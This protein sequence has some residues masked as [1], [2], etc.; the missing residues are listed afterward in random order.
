MLFGK[1][2]KNNALYDLINDNNVKLLG[3]HWEFQWYN[4]E[5]LYNDI[6]KYTSKNI[7]LVNL[8]TPPIKLSTIQTFFFPTKILSDDILTVV[9]CKIKSFHA[10][11]SIEDVLVDM[12]KFIS[13][14][15]L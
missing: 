12:Q 6:Q 4:I 10:S 7:K 2:L 1:G 8:V 3:S 13:N 14:C 11:H 9:K 5:W 15:K